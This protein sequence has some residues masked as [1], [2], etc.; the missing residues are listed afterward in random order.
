MADRDAWLG[1][2]LSELSETEC[3]VLRLAGQLMERVADAK[4]DIAISVVTRTPTD[5]RTRARPG[6]SPLRLHAGARD[7]AVG[8]DGGSVLRG[9]GPSHGGQPRRSAP[10]G[11]AHPVGLAV[12]AGVAY[13]WQMGSSIEIYY[14]AAVRSMSMSWHDFIFGA[15]D[16]AGT[17]SVD[18]LPGALWVQALSVR[19]FG[20][21]TWA[22]ALPQVVEGVLTVLVLYRVVRRLAGAQAAIVAAAVLAIS[23]AAVTLDRGNIPDTLL[24]LLLVLAADAVVG[25]S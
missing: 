9:A 22:I 2:A 13:G 21:H 25:A 24:I 14:A 16:P 17:V 19:L 1:V 3:E 23:P 7:V 4:P 10:L 5:L 18:K 12:V 8:P 15:F 6:P 20:V 11:S